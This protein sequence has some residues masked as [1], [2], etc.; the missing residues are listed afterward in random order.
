MVLRSTAATGG[1]LHPTKL[2]CPGD[3]RF[4]NKL[5]EKLLLDRVNFNETSG[6]CCAMVGFHGFHENFSLQGRLI[7]SQLLRMSTT[8]RYVSH[9]ALPSA[10]ENGLA[11]CG[12]WPMP[13]QSGNT[14]AQ[15]DCLRWRQL[16][17]A[18]LALELSV[19]PAEVSV[20]NVLWIGFSLCPILFSSPCKY[21]S[22]RGLSSKS[23]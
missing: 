1:I 19:G 12:L 17:R 15:S 7:Q 16:W 22:L 5:L 23:S 14:K 10:T 6:L 18:M 21:N 13:G 2:T 4:P 9:R 11:T 20:A 8:W 3:M